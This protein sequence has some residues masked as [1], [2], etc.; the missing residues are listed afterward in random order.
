MNMTWIYFI[1][2]SIIGYIGISIFGRLV[3]PESTS[4][5]NAL[6]S[7]FKPLP[8]GVVLVANA[9]LGGALYFGFLTTQLAI[10]IAISV[11][12]LTSFVFSVAFLGA[13]VTLIKIVG[14]LFIII[15]IYLLR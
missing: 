2:L 3:G 15:G 4:F 12:V 9:L 10:P 13:Q 8:L 11:G 6:I 5:T 1:G 14:L 7:T